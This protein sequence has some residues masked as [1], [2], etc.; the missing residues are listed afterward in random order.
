MPIGNDSYVNNTLEVLR[1][2]LV[3]S[4]KIYARKNIVSGYG[5][6][7]EDLNKTHEKKSNEK[8]HNASS[9]IFSKRKVDLLYNYYIVELPSNERGKYYG[10]TPVGISY[11]CKHSDNVDTLTFEKIFSHLRFFYEKGKP[12]T[13][14][15]SYWKR[16]PEDKIYHII[17][18][19]ILT[20][21]TTL[22]SDLYKMFSLAYELPTG[23][24]DVFLTQIHWERDRNEFFIDF[25]LEKKPNEKAKRLITSDTFN[26]LFTKFVIKA[27]LHTL[28]YTQ[29]L[30]IQ[31]LQ[32]KLTIKNSKNRVKIMKQI[33]QSES[34]LDSFDK[35]GLL[36]VEKFNEDVLN[37]IKLH[38]NDLV[39][40]SSKIK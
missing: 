30:D 12:K 6:K 26:Y 37:A 14:I 15:S 40:I 33:K 9:K 25:D 4:E 10:I 27:V 28:Y 36:L 11:F 21:I 22:G 16:L 23:G 32:K 19:D 18:Q 31:T 1:A 7:K 13:E 39:K 2:F 35:R 24:I 29:V 3:S 38:T 20:K 8:I 5:L 17:L 34:I